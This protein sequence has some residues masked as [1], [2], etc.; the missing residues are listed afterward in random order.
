MNLDNK[1]NYILKFP[2]KFIN[3]YEAFYAS[4]E[5]YLF[6]EKFISQVNQ[7][8]ETEEPYALNSTIQQILD[9]YESFNIPLRFIDGLYLINKEKIEYKYKL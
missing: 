3:Q 1:I 9:S 8:I 5:Q 4:E 2:S 6:C 7:K